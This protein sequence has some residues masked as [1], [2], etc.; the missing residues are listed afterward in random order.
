[1]KVMR[2]RHRLLAYVLSV[3]LITIPPYAYASDN[4]TTGN[5]GKLEDGRLLATKQCSG[6]HAIGKHGASSRSDAP[7]FRHILSRYRSDV[8]QEELVEGI[9]V[10]H[11]DM[12]QFQLNPAAVD[13]LIVYLRSIQTPEHRQPSSGSPLKERLK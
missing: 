7:V 6:C 3:A 12:P 5:Q 11:P 9:K 1:M 10:G 8:L 13:A 2:P 4:S